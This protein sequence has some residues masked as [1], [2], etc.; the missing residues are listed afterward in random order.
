MKLHLIGLLGAFLLAACASETGDDAEATTES[1]AT[2]PD[3][4]GAPYPIV[5]LHGM[6]G[7]GKLE[8]GPIEVTYFK[9]VVEELAKNGEA[10][11]VTLAPPYDT[12]EVRARA[13]AEQIDRILARTGKRK[14]NLIGHSQ[15]GLDARVL[16]SPNGLGYGDRVA[17]ITTISTPHRGS[18]FADTILD[19]V[20]RIPPGVV[21]PVLDGALE[22][23]QITAY[24]LKT[25][26][27]IRAQGT[28]LT[29]R[30]MKGVFNPTYVDDP[31]VAYKSYAGRTNMRTGILDCG[32]ATYAN[33]PWDVL[34]A[35]PM[36][37][38]LALFLEEGAKLKVNDGLVTVDSARWGT[39]E[40]CV[41]AD[42][43]QEVGQLGPFGWFD[44][45]ALFKTIVKRTRKAGL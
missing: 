23:L 9:G 2:A 1:A 31:R 42:H 18:K 28:M 19:L 44:S 16:A 17:S 13:I 33:E 38:P 39:F 22:L 14:V 4:S 6:A 25:D 45:V 40:E 34:P 7:F 12:S 37:A 29:E 27:H 11:Y 20:D 30:Y 35:Q 36:L 15:G 21:D 26:A 5:L 32:N 41:A 10:V 3:P 8:V 24:E 43:L